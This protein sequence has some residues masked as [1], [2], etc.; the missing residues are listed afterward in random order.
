MQGYYAG[1]QC[2]PTMAEALV[3][4][5]SLYPAVTNG[6]VYSL[7]SASNFVSPYYTVIQQHFDP[8]L[9]DYVNESIQGQYSL[10]TLPDDYV[11]MGSQDPTQI[12]I[13][14]ALIFIVAMMD[15]RAGYRP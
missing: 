11:G 3:H 13:L 6:T 9:D 14:F 4:V 5:K 10:C 12:Y 15:F 8:V 7:I 2:V 1:Q